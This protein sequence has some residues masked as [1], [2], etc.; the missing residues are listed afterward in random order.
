ME[1]LDLSP[2]STLDTNWYTSPNMAAA[3]KD[4]VAITD[5]KQKIFVAG[6]CTYTSYEAKI[7]IFDILMD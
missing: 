2:N 7:E 6:G 4:M 1:R 5:G 3:R